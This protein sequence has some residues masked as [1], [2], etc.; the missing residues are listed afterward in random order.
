MAAQLPQ[1]LPEYAVF[2][3]KIAK[4]KIH[5]WGVYADEAIPANRKVIEYTGERISRRETKIRAG[6]PLNYI[7]TLDAYWSIDGAAG[8]SG[9]QYFNHCCQPNVDAR[10]LRGHILYFSKRKIKKGEELTLDYRFAKDVERVP[11]SCGAAECRGTINL[12]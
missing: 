1:I 9:A 12:K 11:C 7:F 3:L 8:G 6:R 2:R 10:I 5:R 4:S